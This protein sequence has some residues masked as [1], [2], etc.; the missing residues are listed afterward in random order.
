MKELSAE[1]VIRIPVIKGVNADAENIK[2]SADS[3]Q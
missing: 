1:I 3:I 2:A